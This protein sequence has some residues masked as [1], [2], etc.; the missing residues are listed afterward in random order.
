MFSSIYIPNKH[1]E[2]VKLNEKRLGKIFSV[3]S[4]VYDNKIKRIFTFMG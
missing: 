4:V 2:K 3:F 1:T